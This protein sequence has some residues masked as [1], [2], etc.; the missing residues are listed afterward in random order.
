ALAH[1]ELWL[2]GGPEG[3]AELAPFLAG[4]RFPALARLG[5]R[6]CPF[7]DELAAALVS[8]PMT[9]RLEALGLSLGNLGDG[10]A[11]S[12]LALPT[13][14]LKS[15]DVTHHY[16]TPGVLRELKRLPL[17]VVADGTRL[18]F[19]HGPIE[20][21]HLTGGPARDF[22]PRRGLGGPGGAVYR[23]T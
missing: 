11:R 19:W 23:V 13:G 14:S 21:A 12:L 4:D 3:L 1:L 5:L 16:V 6:N 9:R 20:P 17:S 22:H 10:G 18:L 15:L 8:A 2:G 7:A